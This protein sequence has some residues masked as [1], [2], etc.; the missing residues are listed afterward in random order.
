MTKATIQKAIEAI[1]N[2]SAVRSVNNAIDSKHNKDRNGNPIYRSYHTTTGALNEVLK[3]GFFINGKEPGDKE[4]YIV[5]G[6]LQKTIGS[7]MKAYEKKEYALQLASAVMK[8]NVTNI[9]HWL[10]NQNGKEEQE[11]YMPILP[12]YGLGDGGTAIE[13]DAVTGKIREIKCDTIVVCLKKEREREPLGFSISYV[14][15][16]AMNPEKKQTGRDLL[17]N[18]KETRMY[19]SAEND[20]I[21]A[22][23]RCETS[24]NFKTPVQYRNDEYA[25]NRTGQTHVPTIYLYAP[26]REGGQYE[27]RRNI[28]EETLIGRQ[29]QG[30][31]GLMFKP[32]E[33]SRMVGPRKKV[34]D[35]RLLGQDGVAKLKSVLSQLGYD[36]IGLKRIQQK[37]EKDRTARHKEPQKQQAAQKEQKEAIHQEAKATDK[38]V[39]EG[40]VKKENYSKE[41]TKRMKKRHEHAFTRIG[42]IPAFKEIREQLKANENKHPGGDEAPGGR[43]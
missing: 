11:F 41:V 35:I 40:K 17:P 15:P 26:A 42:D 28:E 10:S 30:R 37:I 13:Q 19:K 22:F 21:R 38:E 18:L 43:D 20:L 33:I 36:Y 27:L 25:R 6:A 3:Q 32:S 1:K 9:E 24:L 12:E 16:K 39:K 2:D 5:S 4:N 23:Y 34:V 8:H 14:Q 7:P 31:S 29:E